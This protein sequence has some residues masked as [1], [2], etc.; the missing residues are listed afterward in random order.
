[1]ATRW[2]LVFLGLYGT[3][4]LVGCEADE[5]QTPSPMA[6]ATESSLLT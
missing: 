2:I 4:S 1:M 6:E 3:I 5:G